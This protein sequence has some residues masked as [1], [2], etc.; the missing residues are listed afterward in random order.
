M[1]VKAVRR[2]RMS[3]DAM[4]AGASPVDELIGERRHKDG[5][6]DAIEIIPAMVSFRTFAIRS[7]PQ[8]QAIAGDRNPRAS[9]T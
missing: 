9:L 7:C 1:R 4:P 6:F 8:G 3:R 5:R 2:M